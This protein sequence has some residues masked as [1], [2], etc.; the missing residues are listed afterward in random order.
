MLQQFVP[1]RISRIEDFMSR[2]VVTANYWNELFNLLIT[3]GEHAQDALSDIINN[4]EYAVGPN[5]QNANGSLDFRPRTIRFLNTDIVA[6]D[7]DGDVI[8]INGLTGPQGPQ[9]PQGMPAPGLILKGMYPDS[10]SLI[11]AHPIGQVGDVYLVGDI[12]TNTTYIWNPGTMT[13]VD[14]GSLQG[15]PGPG[16][17][18]GGTT[19]QFLLKTSDSDYDTH[20]GTVTLPSEMQYLSGLDQN[21]KSKFDAIDLAFQNVQTNITLTP[22]KVAIS[23]AEGK[24]LAS[25]ISVAELGHLNGVSSNIQTQLNGKLGASATAVNSTKWSGRQCFVGSSIPSGAIDGD[26]WFKVV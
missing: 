9:G 17:P 8:A 1:K 25:A 24:L 6:E 21:I 15:T 4:H 22:S 7:E 19:G 26:I 10:V 5:I 18:S 12:Q 13:W 16:V 23:D 11:S 20:W 3:Q 14:G 2:G